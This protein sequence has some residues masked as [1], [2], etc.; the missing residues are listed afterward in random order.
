ML[1]VRL[2]LMLLTLRR[3][4]AR[5]ALAISAVA[6]AIAAMMLMF[7]LAAGA[8]EQLRTIN[9]QLGT[10]LL[11]ISAV[12]IP[13]LPGRPQGWF[14]SS[15]LKWRDVDAL[16]AV[17]TVAPIVEIPATAA[18]ERQAIT[19]TVR[20]V[21]AAYLDLRH[22][23]VADGRALDGDDDAARKRVALVG[24]YVARKLNGGFSM[25]G[26]TIWIGRVP[27]EVVGQLREKGTSVEGLNEDDQ[28]L[29]PIATAMRRLVNTDSFS[30][31]LVQVPAASDLGPALSRIR[32]VLR[33]S[34]RL[35]DGVKDDFR[36]LSLIRANEMRA[37]NSE[38][39]RG[40]AAIFSAVTLVIGGAGVLAVTFLN[41]KDRIAEIGLR[42]AIGARPRD[43]L[44]LFV[45]EASVL[46]AAGG[47]AGLVIGRI[48]IA[49]L[50]RFIGWTM[51]VDARG[52]VVPFVVSVVIG[53]VFSVL[54]AF[55]AASVMPVDALREQ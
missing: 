2:K 49:L 28:V 45:G 24:S 50:V 52:V 15:R 23:R 16:R 7:A 46:S 18:F 6:L 31:L 33:V 8:N 43:I 34:H 21:T 55:R 40:L 54:P 47:I 3:S 37:R 38:F 9:E 17:G 11:G 10:N 30:G 13:A 29:I 19:T 51:T 53:L 42:V 5:A 14:V 32:E 48:G 26:E 41:V 22:F 27:F 35:D 20:G 4:G 25:V 44:R 1:L 39:L 36:V 12:E